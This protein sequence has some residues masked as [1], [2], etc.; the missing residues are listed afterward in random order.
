MRLA[1][2][3]AA[4]MLCVATS[5]H[6]VDARAAIAIARQRVEATDSRASGHLVRVNANGKRVSN[7]FTLEAHW[8]P[9]V[10]RALI[11]IV[12]PRTPAENAN[13]DA[14][15][16]ILLEMRPNGQNTIQIFRP[17]ESA[18]ALLPFDK[19]SESVFGSDFNYEDFLQPEFYWQNQTILRSDKFGV[20]DCD[21]LKS[22]PEGSNRSHYVEVQT[23]LDHNINYPVYV[24]KTPKDAAGVKE[25]TYS[26]LTQSGGVWAARQVGV[27]VRG[28]PGLTL[29]L[30]EHGSTRAN[31]NIRDFSPEKISH[32]EDQP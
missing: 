13:Q 3:V 18:P 6:A 30:I 15:V 12:P 11:E 21:V 20:H 32:F 26:G 29:L 22:V 28:R 27:K 24:E 10:L 17:H 14:R 5:A 2:F 23:W 8:F 31:L 4:A 25:F 1:S 9:G 7:A 16:S 19:W